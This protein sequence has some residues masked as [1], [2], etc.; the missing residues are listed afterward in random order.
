MTK[1]VTP[2]LRHLTTDEEDGFD[3]AFKKIQPVIQG[4]ADTDTEN[5]LVQKNAVESVDFALNSFE[6]TPEKQR[7]IIDKID[8]SQENLTPDEVNILKGI[9]S[10]TF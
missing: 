7:A 3:I 1:Q 10:R 5:A 9:V 4:V 6:I 8:G 2:I